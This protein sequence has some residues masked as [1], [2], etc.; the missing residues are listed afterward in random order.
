MKIA[1]IM[2]FKKFIEIYSGY[3]IRLKLFKFLLNLLYE[4]FIPIW[5][6]RKSNFFV[7]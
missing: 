5:V 3:I 2:T 4:K 6:A 1:A 7:Y